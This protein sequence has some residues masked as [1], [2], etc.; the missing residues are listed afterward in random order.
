VWH[1]VSPVASLRK[2]LRL[3][4]VAPRP[5]AWKPGLRCVAELT[6]ADLSSVPLLQE[7]RA[8][9]VTSARHLSYTT[10]RGR[11]QAAAA[12]HAA[13]ATAAAAA[14]G[15]SHQPP[16]AVHRASGGGGSLIMVCA[17]GAAP[18]AAAQ[19]WPASALPFGAGA[20][21]YSV[22]ENGDWFDDKGYPVDHVRFVHLLPRISLTGA[23]CFSYFQYAGFAGSMC[24]AIM[25]IL[26]PS[27]AH[28]EPL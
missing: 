18:G 3:P 1:A 23:A 8:A 26:E 4:R 20:G 17:A 15:G 24:G 10:A 22:A 28:C 2:D 6:P 14:P 13:G 25:P 12:R 16:S 11:A 5:V 9:H 7:Q 19:A 27:A 21:D